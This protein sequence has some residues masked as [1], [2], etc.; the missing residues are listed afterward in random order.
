MTEH[1]KRGREERVRA[2]LYEVQ[3][4]V[5]FFS[6]VGIAVSCCMML[7][8]TKMT[9]TMGLTLTAPD[10]QQAAKLTMANVLLITTVFAVFDKFRRIYMV[11]RPVRR[12][13]Q[14]ADRMMQGDFDV[15]IAP[16]HRFDSMDGLQDIADCMNRMAQELSGTETLRTDFIA[17]VSHELKTPLT[18]I[19]NYAAMI[20]QPGLD[21]AQR[22]EYARAISDTA[23]RLANL[24]TNI[25]RLNKLENQQI[26]PSRERFD[27][28]EQ[29]CACLIDFEDAWEKKQLDI[30]TDIEEGVYVC[31]DEELLTLVWNNLFSNAVK[32]TDQGGRISLSLYT[33]GGD[34]VVS[35]SDTGCGFGKEVG[36][37]IFEKFY[38]GDPSRATQG[39]GLGL[40]LVRRVVDI[41]GGD[42]AVSSE[43][44][45]GSTFVVRIR[46][47]CLGA[48]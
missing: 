30:E 5:V 48:A 42:I 9:E 39:N 32:F 38:Q 12:I 20:G 23:R 43:T 14:A 8:V 34:A 6:L 45:R 41:V 1:G 2:L 16:L 11:E 37:H 4:Y 35:V 7:F 31:C 17:N 21:E 40:A 44:G 29:L 46:K 22:R 13:M 19:H 3:R 26:F 47:D 25:L 36:A 33:D 18:V 15:R 28:G 10:I 27:L 24:I